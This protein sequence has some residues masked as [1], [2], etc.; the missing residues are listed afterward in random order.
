MKH[1][2]RSFLVCC[3]LCFLCIAGC[4]LQTDENPSAEKAILASGAK[5]Y[6]DYIGLL[7]DNRLIYRCF[8]K[9]NAVYYSYDFDTK[10]KTYLGRTEGHLDSSDKASLLNHHLYFYNIISE[11]G[12]DA[13]TVF[14]DIDLVSNTIAELPVSEMKQDG[15][16]VSAQSSWPLGNTIVA[17]AYVTE[18]ELRI[19]NLTFY[20]PD[21]GTWSQKQLGIY[22]DQQKTG[23][24][25]FALY[26]D[27]TN[28]YLL[29]GEYKKPGTAD[30]YFVQ[31]DQDGNLLRKICLTGS[32]KDYVAEKGVWSLRVW[33]D[34]LYMTNADVDDF[35]GYIGSD[36]ITEVAKAPLTMSR[37]L[38]SEDAPVFYDRYS[39]VY[40][41]LDT[42]SATL[43]EHQHQLV[44]EYPTELIRALAGFQYRTNLRNLIT[45]QEK[46]LI[47]VDYHNQPEHL[48]LIDRTSIGEIEV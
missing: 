22:D 43:T 7:E 24:Y 5:N 34:Y 20:H 8:V 46:A 10:E 37:S 29:Q 42:A 11:K 47:V 48:F 31:Y 3:F 28:L 16:T 6:I 1:K 17:L 35:I 36:E 25:P 18:N 2:T 27:G 44:T 14:Y 26:A 19:S 21:T 45:A 9:R 4:G 30:Y 41:T 32:I 38:Y 15:K 40:Y 33:N 23:M 39:N 12:T 13:R